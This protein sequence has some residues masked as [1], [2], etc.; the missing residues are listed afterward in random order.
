M[1]EIDTEQSII[2]NVYHLN[3]TVYL[4]RYENTS[5]DRY[6]CHWNC[7]SV[8]N[9]DI[10]LSNSTYINTIYIDASV[11]NVSCSLLNM[12]FNDVREGEVICLPKQS[13]DLLCFEE[14]FNRTKRSI[15][16]TESINNI[17]YSKTVIDVKLAN[18]SQNTD[19]K[20]VDSFYTS[21]TF[22]GFV[23]LMCLGTVAFN[24]ANC[25]GDAVC[26]DVLG[27]LFIF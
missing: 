16:K 14:E 20:V 17:D 2:E 6:S 25:I 13:C 1:P 26:F 5:L 15:D 12:E 22:W 11:S 9:F 7:T 19:A 4:K 3:D 8:P 24:V 23:I 18:N 21:A 27:E 10:Y